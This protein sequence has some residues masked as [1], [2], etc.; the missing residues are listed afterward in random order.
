VRLLPFGIAIAPMSHPFMTWP[1]PG[2][3]T[4]R[5][6]R[7]EESILERNAAK[8]WTFAAEPKARTQ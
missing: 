1:I 7:E 5:S 4:S 8:L 2:Q 3:H 6:K